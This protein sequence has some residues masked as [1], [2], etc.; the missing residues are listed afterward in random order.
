VA[1]AKMTLNELLAITPQLIISVMLVV[2]LLAVAW[3]RSRNLQNQLTLLTL[4]MAITS[5]VLLFAIKPQAVTPLLYFDYAANLINIFLLTCALACVLTSS[6]YLATMTEVHDEFYLL[7]LL[8][9]LGANVLVLSKHF[10]ALFIGLELMSISLVGL[11]G[12]L[13]ERK[14]ALEASFKLLILSATASSFLMLGVAFVYGVTGSLEFFSLGLVSNLQGVA[15]LAEH[16]LIY[17]AGIVLVLVGLC[18]K[19]S[20]APFHFWT[21][22]VYH[23]APAPV[24][25]LLATVSKGAVLFTL[26]KLWFASGQQLNS[27]IVLIISVLAFISMLVGNFLALFQSN[28]KRLLAY[29]SVAHMGYILVVL[30]VKEP[31]GIV[32]AQEA[33]VFYLFTYLT[34]TLIVFLFICQQSKAAWDCDDDQWLS[35]KGLFWSRPGAAL[36]LIIAFLSLAGIPLTAGFIGKFYLINSLVLTREWYL[37]AALIVGSGLGLFYYLRII[38]ALFESDIQNQEKNNNRVLGNAL[39]ALFSAVV[40]FYGVLPD[41]LSHFLQMIFT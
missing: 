30:V 5:S 17:F 14:Q 27:N 2:M 31:Q 9:V 8:S 19:L 18:F 25:M 21:P 11:A 4:L 16:Q 29:S 33:A 23:G 37:L 28:I 13:R 32:F 20:I 6:K 3:R 7:L 34:A 12:Y 39:L 1:E 41:R 40:V 26:I 15:N 24:S 35:W 10:A 22:D 36:A 38:F